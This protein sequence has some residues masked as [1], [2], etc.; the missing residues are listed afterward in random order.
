MTTCAEMF[1]A[2]LKAK[3]L[4][5]QVKEL[6]DKT[7]VSFPYDNRKTNFV[8]SG[9]DGKYAQMMTVIERVPE[10]KFTDLVL[11]C[12]SLNRQYRFVKFVVDDDND[13]MAISDAILDTGTADEECF[14]LLI[15]SLKIIGDAKPDLMKAI[16]S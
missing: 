7:L 4:N 9:E 10:E 8:F 14:E 2:N 3:N 1:V 11:V 12:N 13:C 5:Y 15:R 16:Y 6:G